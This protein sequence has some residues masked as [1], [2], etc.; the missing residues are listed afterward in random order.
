MFWI[1]ICYG[2]S[3]FRGVRTAIIG[4]AEKAGVITLSDYFK[5]AKEKLFKHLLEKY[6][7]EKHEV[8]IYNHEYLGR[9]DI[10]S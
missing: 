7:I 4:V 5:D 6:V 1:K 8:I 3:D 10:I 2:C 9:I